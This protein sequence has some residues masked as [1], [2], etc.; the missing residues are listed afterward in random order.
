MG[1][2]KKERRVLIHNAG[3]GVG[4]AVWNRETSSAPEPTEQRALPST[5]LAK[6]AGWITRSII[7]AG[8]VAGADDL[9]GGRGSSAYSIRWAARCWKKAIELYER[10][11]AWECL[12]CPPRRPRESR[13]KLA[14]FKAL[15]QTPRFHPL[16]LMNRNR[17]FLL[18]LGHM[19]AKARSRR[20]DKRDRSCESMK[21]GFN[22]I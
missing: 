16:A 4:L 12:A 19:W 21:V 5:F 2:L 13:G 17:E 18:N 9:T 11:D 7:V 14:G 10:P 6:R 15:A 1:G 8:L 20:L 3:G 22:L